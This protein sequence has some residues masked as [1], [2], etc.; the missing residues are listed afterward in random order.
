MKRKNRSWNQQNV[1]NCDFESCSGAFGF[2]LSV[3][4]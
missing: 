1:E 2:D 4:L 3:K